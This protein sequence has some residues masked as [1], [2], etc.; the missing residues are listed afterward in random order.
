MNFLSHF[1]NKIKYKKIIFLNIF[2]FFNT[3]G[4]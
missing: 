2:F 1:Y 3:F 4:D